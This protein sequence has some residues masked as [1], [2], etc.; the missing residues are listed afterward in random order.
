MALRMI[1]YGYKMINGVLSVSDEESTVVKEVFQR[2]MNGEN[3]TSIADDLTNREIIYF[4]EKRVWNK[5]MIARILENRKY[6]GEGDYPQII[7][8]ED[9]EQA[10]NLKSSK[11]KKKIV[12]SSEIEYLKSTLIC[13]QCGHKLYRRA[14]WST[15]E[16]WVCTFGCKHDRYIGD[17]EISAGIMNALH[18]P[19]LDSNCLGS[20]DEGD[21][22]R[23]GIDVVKQTNEIKRL[24]DQTDVQFQVLKTMILQCASMKF[25]CCFDNPSNTY[26]DYVRKCFAER[27]AGSSLDVEFMK[28][29]S[30]DVLLEKDGSV[31]V[32]LINGAQITGRR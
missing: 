25:Q 26:S 3:L 16:K 4:Q 10:N 21:T 23:P 27:K 5:N 24:M 22:Y 9:F 14:N 2:Y 20:C 8:S 30:R 6:V 29:V 28:K 15:R 18:Q 1:T 13:A 32:T 31:T 19:M 7:S 12:C 17:A 11:A